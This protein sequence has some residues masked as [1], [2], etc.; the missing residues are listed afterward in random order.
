TL[1]A[2]VDGEVIGRWAEPGEAVAAGEPVLSLGEGG[3]PWTRVYV[4]AR[5]LPGVRVGQSV[6][7]TLDGVPGRSFAGRVA[8]IRGRAEFTPRV[9]LTETERADLVFAVRV[10]LQ[11]RGGMLRAGMP[12]TVTFPAAPG[13][14]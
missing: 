8:S 14:R 12:V 1:T 10:E 9:A 6:T 3:R 13:N 4:D 5:T 7:A 2:A 11:D